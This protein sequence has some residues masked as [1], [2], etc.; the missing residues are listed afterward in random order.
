MQAGGERRAQSWDAVR[1]GTAFG[2]HLLRDVQIR[3]PRLAV[4]VSRARQPRKVYLGPLLAE[5]WGAQRAKFSLRRGEN[6]RC[7]RQGS[8]VA[9][10]PVTWPLLARRPPPIPR[11]PTR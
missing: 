5:P 7:A 3:F 10:I 6:P 9:E 8:A 4:L 2:P 1:P 11:F